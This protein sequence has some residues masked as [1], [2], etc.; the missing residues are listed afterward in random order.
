MRNTLSG[1]GD[2][3]LGTSLHEGTIPQSVWEVNGERG[4]FAIFWLN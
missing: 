1:P 2:K 4:I 3:P